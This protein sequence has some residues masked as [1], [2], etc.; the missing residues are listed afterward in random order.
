MRTASSDTWSTLKRVVHGSSVVGDPGLCRRL[1]LFQ[2][3]DCMRDIGVTGVQ[4]CALPISLRS[5]ETVVVFEVG[6]AGRSLASH[7]GIFA[8]TGM[9]K[10]NLM[11]VLAGD[12]LRAG[13]RYGLLLIDRSEERRVGERGRSRRSR[14]H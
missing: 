8:T 13:G 11:M 2:A 6:I 5:G 3:E 14:Y 4:T 9:G 12:V 1:L 10:S 7:V